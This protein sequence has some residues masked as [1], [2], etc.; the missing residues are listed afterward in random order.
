MELIDKIKAIIGRLEDIRIQSNPNIEIIKRQVDFIENEELLNLD[1]EFDEWINSLYDAGEP[2]EETNKIIDKIGDLF[3]HADELIATIRQQFEIE[4][5]YD[6][7][8]GF[9]DEEQSRT[10]WDDDDDYNDADDEEY[11]IV[12]NEVSKSALIAIG[13]DNEDENSIKLMGTILIGISSEES[14]D[15]IAG[16]A[17]AQ[18]ALSGFMLPM[19]KIKEIVKETREKCKK[20]VFGLQIAFSNLREYNCSAEE[21]LSQIQLFL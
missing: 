8:D 2:D 11:D 13:I 6:D 1:K 21:A 20:Q 3:I 10:A 4:D 17:L 18:L 15:A 7:I 16:R 19:E 5:V 9:D 12:L 14:D